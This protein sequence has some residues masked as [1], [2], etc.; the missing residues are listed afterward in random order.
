[1]EHAMLYSKSF[2][3]TLQHSTPDRSQAPSPTMYTS[4]HGNSTA[5]SPEYFLAGEPHSH[6]QPPQC[7]QPFQ[8]LL[9]N[10]VPWLKYPPHLF[11]L[12]VDVR[13]RVTIPCQ[14]P[15]QP[16]VP[17]RSGVCPFGMVFPIGQLQT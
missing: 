17:D 16:I 7:T 5:G 12:P 11:A 9:A 8:I 14:R 13:P 6:S 15:L 3:Q 4:S 2:P 10:H 1:M